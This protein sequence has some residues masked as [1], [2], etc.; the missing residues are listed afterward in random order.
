MGPVTLGILLYLFLT[1]SAVLLLTLLSA[2]AR[3]RRNDTAPPT[4]TT[5]TV[6]VVALISSFF[7]SPAGVVLGHLGMS[8][9]NRSNEKGWGLAL[10]GAIIGYIGLMA[11]VSAGIVLLVVLA[12]AAF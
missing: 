2:N 11:W 6:C 5:N 1:A 12:F 9:V 4:G 10:T 3:A 7:V 8:Q